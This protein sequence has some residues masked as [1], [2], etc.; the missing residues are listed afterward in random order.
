MIYPVSVDA[1][2]SR[3][4]RGRGQNFL[5]SINPS[6]ISL[7]GYVKADMEQQQAVL[8]VFFLNL[9]SAES[10]SLKKI[11]FSW[12]AFFQPVWNLLTGERLAVPW[13]A[14][15]LDELCGRV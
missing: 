5:V 9:C 7:L 8:C 14:W 2:S 15:G 13:P 12:F 10:R 4:G 11:P 3:M 1:R 6:D